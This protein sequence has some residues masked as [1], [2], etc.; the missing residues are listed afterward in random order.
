MVL[1]WRQPIFGKRASCVIIVTGPRDMGVSGTLPYETVMPV[2]VSPW[3]RHPGALT[4]R[5][6]LSGGRGSRII[7]GD[8]RGR[9]PF[10][11][12][13]PD[14]ACRLHVTVVENILWSSGHTARRLGNS[15]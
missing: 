1:S 6:G 12:R 14:A 8:A 13:R 9:D 2:G 3:C 5:A 10:G 7:A 11:Y 15:A 4:R